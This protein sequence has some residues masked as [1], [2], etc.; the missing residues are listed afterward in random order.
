TPRSPR[1]IGFLF[2][3]V[4]EFLTQAV[5]DARF[6]HAHR[7]RTHAQVGRDVLGSLALD[8][9]SPK[10]LPGTLF[11]FSPDQIQGS[12]KQAAFGGFLPPAACL[13]R[14]RPRQ[15]P[16]PPLSPRATHAPRSPPQLAEMVVHLVVRNRPQPTPKRVALPLLAETADVRRHGLKDVLEDVRD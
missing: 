7:P 8:G 4:A 6:G 5:E 1:P 16:H 2:H 10:G 12:I 13:V 15:L 14:Q 3:A 9:G 11:E